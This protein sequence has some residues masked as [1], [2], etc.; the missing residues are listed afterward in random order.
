MRRPG[1]KRESQPSNK[2]NDHDRNSRNTESNGDHNHLT[3]LDPSPTCS[4]PGNLLSPDWSDSDNFSRLLAPLDPDLISVFQGDNDTIDGLFTSPMDPLELESNNFFSH[5]PDAIP[6]A[7]SFDHLNTSKSSSL[8]SSDQSLLN[9]TWGVSGAAGSASCCLIQALDL[10]RELSAIKPSVCIRSTGQNDAGTVS[11]VGPDANLSAQNVVAEN[12]QTFEM[13]NNM[14][15]CPC[16]EDSYLLIILS[17]IVMKALDRYAAAARKQFWGAGEKGD[18]SRAST[19][20]HE[21]VP[22]LSGVGDE[23]PGRL[24]AQLILGK[25]HTVQRLVK[26]LSPRLKAHGPETA[27]EGGGDLERDIVRGDWQIASPSEG[28]MTPAPL[29]PTVFEQIDLDLRKALS[30]LSSEIINMLRQN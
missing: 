21:Q 14:L 10:M 13:V 18:K 8:S 28:G 24:G 4:T 11:T 19:S 22:Q 7:S 2:D 25:L 23:N 30:G 5:N 1:R 27:S 12:Q 9:G 15:Q 6:E 16:M 20:T 17:M 26:Q 3:T 29:S